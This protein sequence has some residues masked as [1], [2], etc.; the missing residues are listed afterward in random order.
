MTAKSKS[1]EVVTSPIGEIS[2]RVKRVILLVYGIDHPDPDSLAGNTPMSGFSFNDFQWMELAFG[3]T[4]IIREHH[5]GQSVTAPELENL[6][7]VQDCIDLV[8]QKSGS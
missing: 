2:D 8:L 3:L 7:N 4:K 1:D 5:P 6:V